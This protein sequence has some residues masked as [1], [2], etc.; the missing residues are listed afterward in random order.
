MSN[1]CK[2][3]V[4]SA[5]AKL[6]SVLDLNPLARSGYQNNNNNTFINRSS[7][8]P[9]SFYWSC[10]RVPMWGGNTARYNG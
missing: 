2:Q 3:N 4:S 10:N 9:L 8:L 6:Q 7:F 1:K 5:P